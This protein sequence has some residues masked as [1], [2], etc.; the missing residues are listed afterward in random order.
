MVYRNCNVICSDTPPG[1][2]VVVCEGY[3]MSYFKT[4]A[5]ALAYLDMTAEADQKGISAEGGTG[6]A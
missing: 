3:A 1:G 4:Q 2:C 5:A 6:G